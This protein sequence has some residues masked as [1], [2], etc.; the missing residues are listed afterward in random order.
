MV[1]STTE[2][3]RRYQLY[4]QGLCE[5]VFRD[6]SDV[7]HAALGLHSTDYWTPYISAWAR[8]G[9]YDAKEV[10]EAL[11]EGRTVLRRRAFR[12]TLHVVHIAN[13]GL[14]L[15]G[16]GPQLE[17]SMRMAPP[18]KDLTD[19]EVEKR[20]KEI[21]Q[22]LQDGPLS[23]NELKKRLPHI[24]EQLRWLI[25]MANGRGQIVR[26]SGTHA[27]STRLDY[28][29]ASNWLSDYEIPVIEE[30]VALAEILHKYI[31]NFGPV[32]VSDI[33]W[34]VPLKT[35]EAKRLL[36]KIENQIIEVEIDGKK[37]LMSSNDF[38]QSKSFEPSSDTIVNLL[39]YEDHF[40]KAFKER[41]WYISQ[42]E[43]KMLFP[44]N[45][46]HY[47][48][49]EMKPPPPGPP[50]GMNASGEIRPSIW[51]DGRI[52]GRWEVETEKDQATIHHA[53]CVKTSK[54]IQERIEEKCLELSEFINRRLMPIS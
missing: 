36:S 7:T 26:T 12:N 4:K 51:V 3:L 44:R 9:D 41:N 17:R 23:M 6:F 18:I 5:R 34:W 22:V 2:H 52:V 21:M 8:I 50:K 47:W 33:A 29:L 40:P 20:I 11:N 28:D 39:P 31:N 24:G 43:E 14:I 45:R 1:D 32:S 15:S 16:L 46:E 48:P 38:E 42:E 37:H 30:D 19:S 35:G 13:Y 53:I 49:P 10:F 25:L 54:D 27:R